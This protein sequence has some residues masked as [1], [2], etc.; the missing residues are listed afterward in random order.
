MSTLPSALTAISAIDGRYG[1]L[2]KDL[3]PIF[4]EFG[5]I[6]TRVEVEVKWL[7]KLSSL[8]FV[9]E[10]P[11]L[12]AEAQAELK[13]IYIEFSLND[14]L[15]V[16]EIESVTK[17]D[18]KAVEYFLKEKV[19]SSAELSAV[20]EFLHFACTSE[21]INN[22]AYAL[23]LK[24][25]RSDVLLKQMDTLIAKVTEFAHKYAA[26][27]ML[28]RTHGQPATPSTLGKE[29]AN[30]AYRL[31]RQRD[32]FAAVEI[33]G[34]AA[35]A[36]G[37]YNAHISAYPDVDWMSVAQEFG[38]FQFCSKQLRDK[39]SKKSILV[40]WVFFLLFRSRF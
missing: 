18:V 7:L 11:S 29:L 32:Q 17:H 15:R 22:L 9:P 38:Y 3:R 35:G 27:P 10:V 16:K 26:Q 25:A 37:N 5:L 20:A 40:G 31:R 21:D 30:F 1:R 19:A 24:E 33:R 39:M 6:R 23:M 13:R 12:T 8:S 28:C 4:S 2:T 36:V 14:G 34:K